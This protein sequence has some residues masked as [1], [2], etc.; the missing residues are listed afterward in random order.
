MYES[1][2]VTTIY[3]EKKSSLCKILWI[4]KLTGI[5]NVNIQ[6]KLFIKYYLLSQLKFSTDQ[7]A[8]KRVE[9]LFT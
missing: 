4:Q 1:I 8:Y 2:V 6:T 3:R 7:R 5:Q 9:E